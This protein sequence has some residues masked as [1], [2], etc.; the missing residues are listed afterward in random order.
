MRFPGAAFLG[1]ALLLACS[2]RTLPP[3]AP[4]TVARVSA[5]DSARSELFKTQQVLVFAFKPHWWWPTIRM[6]ALGYAVVNRKTG[7]YA[8]VCLSPMGV[9]LFEAKRCAGVATVTLA[10]P[11]KG[12]TEAM[13]TAIGKDIESLYFGLTPPP[14]AVWRQGRTVLTASV[15]AGDAREEWSFAAD[16]GWLM[17]KTIRTPEGAR[18]VTFDDYQPLAGGLYP[19]RM[20]LRNNRFGYTMQVRQ[21]RP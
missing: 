14:E 18:T 17:E 16:T 15:G 8:V 7:D 12:N 6:T 1:V 5:L 9:K 13:G 4:E 11:V 19:A 2:C 21:G 3:V 10:C 20:S